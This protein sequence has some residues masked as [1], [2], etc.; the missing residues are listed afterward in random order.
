M[1]VVDGVGISKQ[2][3]PLEMA[4]LA[5]GRA[6]PGT[7]TERAWI[8]SR[9][10]AP[11]VYHTV[12]VTVTRAGVVVEVIVVRSVRTVVATVTGTVA[13]VVRSLKDMTLYD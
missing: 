1:I 10:T 12:V 2:E 4:L 3:Q 8:A 11:G 5:K 13:T 9:L 7:V 6:N